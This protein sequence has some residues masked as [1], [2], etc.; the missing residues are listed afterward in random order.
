MYLGVAVSS[1]SRTQHCV[2]LSTTDA[3]YVAVAEEA[4]E[5]MF[6]RSVLSFLRPRVMLGREMEYDTGLHED[7][8]GAKAL[9]DNPL[10]SARSKHIGVR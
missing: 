2:T 4:K 7:N 9:A 6:L 1:T 8:E 3:E 5:C 10:S